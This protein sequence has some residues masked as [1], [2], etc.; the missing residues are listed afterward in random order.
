VQAESEHI[1]IK[2][3]RLISQ[4]MPIRNKKLST[5]IVEEEARSRAK[6]ARPTVNFDRSDDKKELL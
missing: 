4:D 2:A 1:R 3:S 5:V 6:R